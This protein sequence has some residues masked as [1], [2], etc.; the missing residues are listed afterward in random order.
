MKSRSQAPWPPLLSTLMTMG[1]GGTHCTRLRMTPGSHHPP[2]ITR[3]LHPQY[4]W[5]PGL[6]K[7]HM[8][9]IAS[10]LFLAPVVVHADD[11]GLGRHALNPPARDASSL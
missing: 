10:L 8:N 2:A 6:K 9:H 11:H 1:L 4:S 7:R 5:M 3:T